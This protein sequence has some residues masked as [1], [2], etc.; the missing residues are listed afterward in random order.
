MKTLKDITEHGFNHGKGPKDFVGASYTADFIIEL[1]Q[2]AIEWVKE[3]ETY[4]ETKDHHNWRMIW[5]TKEEINAVIEFI[6][7][8]FNLTDEDLK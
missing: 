2:S 6:K 7:E 8:F 5:S 3:L 4:D 1:R